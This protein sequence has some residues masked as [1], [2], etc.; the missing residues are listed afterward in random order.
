[1]IIIDGVSKHFNGFC[2]VNNFSLRVEPGE[3]FAL[4]GP[5]G[6]GKTT[7]IKM[8][9]GLL[10]PDGGNILLADYDTV[11]EPIK[12]KS[13][14]GYVPDKP[15]LY[16][17]LTAREFM[18]FV[19]SIRKMPR[20]LAVA[21]TESLFDTFGIRD[22]ED[23]LIEGLSRGLRQRLV[24]SAALI[25]SPKILLIDEPFTGLDAFGVRTLREIL[26]RLSLEGVSV[27]L[28]THSLH[29]AED[30]CHRV[31]FIKKGELLATRNKEEIKNIEGGLEAFFLR[32]GS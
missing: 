17:K 10:R 15:F 9:V 22:I 6:A 31:G 5:N 13:I 30:L 32:L 29:L 20:T 23:D 2:A 24:F 27:F 12:A 18:F 26:G 1:M 28:A 16:G 25:N 7:M 11:R 14:L 21:R 8:M 19:S 4:V 3:I